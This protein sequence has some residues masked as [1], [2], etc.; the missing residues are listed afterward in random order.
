MDAAEHMQEAERHLNS[1][2]RAYDNDRPS[3]VTY[4][5]AAAQVH[6]TLA[7]AHATLDLTAATRAATAHAR[8]R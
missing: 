7:G 6:A 8:L 2:A 3:D 4:H 1:A 5:F